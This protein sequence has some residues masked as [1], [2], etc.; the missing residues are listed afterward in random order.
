MPKQGQI[1]SI[2]ISNYYF[3]LK[4]YNINYH[5]NVKAFDTLC[6][7]FIIKKEKKLFLKQKATYLLIINNIL[8]KIIDN[9]F[10]SMNKLNID[11]TFKIAWIDFLDLEKIIYTS[12]KLKKALF[13]STRVI[14]SNIL[15]IKGNQYIVFY[16]K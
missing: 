7:I 14:R 3:T 15:F 16:L 11:I 8:K 6:I 4:F 12:T 2:T 5:L 10:V 9:K 1:K 13:L